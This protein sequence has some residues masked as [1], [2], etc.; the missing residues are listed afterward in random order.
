MANEQNLTMAGK[1][2]DSKE[3]AQRL[4]ALGGKASGESKRRKKAFKELAQIMMDCKPV[5][6]LAEELKQIFPDLDIEDITNRVLMLR[7]QMDKAVFEGDSKAF[8][9]LRDTAGEKPSDKLEMTGKDGEPLNMKYELAPATKEAIE[10]QKKE[11]E[12]LDLL[13]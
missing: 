6:S 3:K 10:E 9:I 4:G 12:V 8:E 11:R 7:K 2:I 13:S 1:A 5:D